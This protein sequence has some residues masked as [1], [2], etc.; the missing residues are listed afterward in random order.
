MLWLS[1]LLEQVF[2]EVVFLYAF[3][4]KEENAD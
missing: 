2:I 4:Y 1:E 3:A